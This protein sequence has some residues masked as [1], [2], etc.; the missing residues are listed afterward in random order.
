MKK[1][2]KLTSFFLLGTFL[3]FLGNC[4][5]KLSKYTYPPSFQYIEKGEI[6]QSMLAMVNYIQELSDLLEA[7]EP[8]QQDVLDQLTKI[9]IAA[10]NLGPN[11][12]N[13]PVLDQNLG[14]FLDDVEV[15]HKT[16]SMTPPNYF[17]AKHLSHSCFEC[18]QKR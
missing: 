18:H 2:S 5:Q 16:A 11:E 3:I 1:I 17:G 15:A 10:Q 4:S 13:H 12:S 7:P 8:I 9:K 14:N 6:S